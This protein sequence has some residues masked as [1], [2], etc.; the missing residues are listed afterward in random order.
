MQIINFTD[1]IIRLSEYPQC[2]EISAIPYADS[3]SKYHSNY[4]CMVTVFP[5]NS[6]T[7][8]SKVVIVKEKSTMGQIRMCVCKW[9]EQIDS[10]LNNKDIFPNGYEVLYDSRV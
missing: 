9:D 1:N 3:K 7:Y 6:D 8:K 10:F 5:C 4:G 2:V